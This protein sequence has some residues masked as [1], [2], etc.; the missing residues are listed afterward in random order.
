MDDLELLQLTRHDVD[1]GGPDNH[2]LVIALNRPK[3]NALST[4]LLHEILQ[5]AE[6]CTADPPGAVVVTGAGR[7][8]AAGAEI[9]EFTDPTTRSA[10]LIAFRDA[11]DAVAGIPCPTIAAVNG[12]AL[13]GGA[14]LAWCCDLRIAGTGAAFGQPEIL[15]GIIPGAGGTQRLPRLI[16]TSRAKELVFEGGQVDAERALALGMVNAVVPDDELLDTAVAGRPRRPSTPVATAT[17]TTAS[18]SRASCSPPCSTPTTRLP[19]SPRSSSTAPARPR[20]PGPDRP[21]TREGPWPIR[22]NC[23]TPSPMPRRRVTA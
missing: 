10:L 12:F 5:V 8:F 7:F 16:G 20:S 2:V 18:T 23:S 3:V 22:L 17:W 1:G 14:E 4:A 21:A 9:S 11:F 6:A 13:G 19:A 15:L